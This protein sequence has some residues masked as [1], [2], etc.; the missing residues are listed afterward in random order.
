MRGFKSKAFVSVR[1]RISG[2]IMRVL[3]EGIQNMQH[4]STPRVAKYELRLDGYI[5][6]RFSDSL[7]AL[8]FPGS[9]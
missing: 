3:H 7:M 2:G 6:Y 8:S 5:S 4:A 1:V 9:N